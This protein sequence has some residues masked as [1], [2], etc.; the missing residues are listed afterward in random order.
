MQRANSLEK[1][2]MLRKIEGK[3]KNRAAENEMVG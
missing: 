1:D 3:K 2:Q